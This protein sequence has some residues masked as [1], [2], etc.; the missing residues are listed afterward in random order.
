MRPDKDMSKFYSLQVSLACAFNDCNLQMVDNLDN[1]ET[2][3][4]KFMRVLL[5]ETI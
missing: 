1:Y 5:E 2:Y 4:V 3:A